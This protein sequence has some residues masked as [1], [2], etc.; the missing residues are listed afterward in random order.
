[1]NKSKRH[2]S[3]SERRREHMMEHE[4]DDLGFKMHRKP[5]TGTSWGVLGVFLLAALAIPLFYLLFGVVS[6]AA[7][8]GTGIILTSIFL[9]ALVGAAIAAVYA[10]LK[11]TPGN[12]GHRHIIPEEQGEVS[13]MTHKIS[14]LMNRNL[15]VCGSLD[16]ISECA[17]IMYKA[18]VGATPVIDAQD[19]CIGIVTDRDIVC[20]GVAQGVDVVTTPV[21]TI[22]ERNF[23]FVR[24]DQDLSDVLEI[25]CDAGIRR[26]LV[27]ENRKCIGLI[28]LDDLIVRRIVDAEDIA[29][30][31][32]KQLAEP[33][34][35]TGLHI[36]E[37]QVA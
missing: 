7:S 3:E 16:S 11:R 18:N 37:E 32:A 9:V 34:P 28:S 14:D 35:S 1:M 23:K 27:L 22:M 12:P 36:D 29:P 5:G 30:I 21:T 8:T 25:M 33:G 24:P 15:V 13:E 19:E 6:S 26:I 20:G 31:F 10:M 17:K 4:G 2:T